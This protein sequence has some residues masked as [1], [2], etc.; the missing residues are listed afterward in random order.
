MKVHLISNRGEEE[1]DLFFELLSKD[2]AINKSQ[3]TKEADGEGHAIFDLDFKKLQKTV[4]NR[5]KNVTLKQNLSVN[6]TL[7]ARIGL[8]R[9]NGLSF[10]KIADKLNAEGF[11]NSRKNKLNRMQVIRLHDKYLIEEKTKLK[12]KK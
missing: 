12:K 11:L 8:Y 9:K 10:Q 3:F 6:K 7:I 1:I 2:I 4:S 5:R